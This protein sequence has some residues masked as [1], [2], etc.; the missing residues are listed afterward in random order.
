M[1]KGFRCCFV[2]TK[3]MVPKIWFLIEK[4]GLKCPNPQLKK[5]KIGKI[6]F[7]LYCDLDLVIEWKKVQMSFKTPKVFISIN[8]ICITSHLPSDSWIEKWLFWK[9]CKKYVAEKPIYTRLNFHF[10]FPI[11]SWSKSMMFRLSNALS[12]M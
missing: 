2:K 11:F 4:L 1:K 7:W 12:T 9:F 8:I 6:D 5:W 10:Y 3:S